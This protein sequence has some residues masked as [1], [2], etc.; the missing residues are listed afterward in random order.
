MT[1]NKTCIIKIF[2]FF[3]T[4]S[5]AALLCTS[6]WSAQR[7]PDQAAPGHVI[8]EIKKAEVRA[9]P[10]PE[11][12]IS[13]IAFK[14]E[15]FKVLRELPD[16][17]LIELSA[18][19]EGYL[20]KKYARVKKLDKS[21][22]GK[23]L[24]PKP[25][26]TAIEQEKD[27][28][29]ITSSGSYIR[30]TPKTN[31]PVIAQ[32]KINNAFKLSRKVS[33]SWYEIVLPNNKI[34]Y[35]PV[36]AAK[37]ITPAQ[38]AKHKAQRKAAI[39]PKTA[40]Q[41]QPAAAQYAVAMKNDIILRQEPNI[42]AKIMVTA[43]PGDHYRILSQE[44]DWCTVLLPDKRHAFVLAKVVKIVKETELTAAINEATRS[45]KQFKVNTVAVTAKSA[46]LYTKANDT[47][48]VITTAV[49]GTVFKLVWV[50]KD[51]YEV[52]T[53]SG[54][55]FI[56][57]KL[58]QPM[59]NE[60]PDVEPQ[61][62]PQPAPPALPVLAV[63]TKVLAEPEKDAW[64]KDKYVLVTANMVNLREAP[65]KNS[66][67]LDRANKD[68]TY[69]LLA[70]QNNWY[71]IFLPPEQNGFIASSLAEII[72]EAD[73]LAGPNKL[74]QLKQER[75]AA[76]RKLRL[77]KKAAEEKARKEEELKLKQENERKIKEDA[78]KR[79]AAIKAQEAEWLKDK[80][81]LINVRKAVLQNVPNIKG[82]ILA[83][84]NIGD[85]FKLVSRRADWY[86]INFSSGTAFINHN[87]GTILSET[88]LAEQKQKAAEEKARKEKELK[89]RQE[90]ERRIKEAA[91]Q[92]AREAA[93]LK[94][95][96]EAERKS[97]LEKQ[98]NEAKAREEEW[99]A[100]KYV[101]INKNNINL[102]KSP[103]KTA[104][105]INKTRN[106]ESFKLV[107]RAKDWYEISLS[108]G[109]AFIASSLA[110]VITAN[111]LEA[112]RAAERKAAAEKERL[113]A[114]AKAK[115]EAEQ[116]AKEEAAKKAREEAVQK[117]REAE[118]LKTRQ[119]AEAKAIDEAFCKD[120]YVAVKSTNAN[121]RAEP[122]L[123]A[124]I[125]ANAKRADIFKLLSR[126]QDWYEIFLP[127]DQNAFIHRGLVDILTE[128]DVES[129]IRKERA[130]LLRKQRAAEE[131]A[132][133][134]E[135]ERRAAEAEKTRLEAARIAKLEREKLLRAEA[136]LRGKE[137]AA[138]KAKEEEE[139]KAREIAWLKDKYIL[140][141]KQ[142]S[143][144][145][146]PN[147][148]ALVSGT[149]LPDTSFKIVTR[150]AEW[151]GVDT[152][153]GT[154]FVPIKQVKLMT[155]Q[156]LNDYR[157]QQ[158]LRRQ[159]KLKEEAEKK[160][161]LE[162]KQQAKLEAERKA[163]EELELKASLAAEEKA[164]KEAA[165]KAKIES[166]VQ[167][168]YI[169]IQAEN[170]NLRSAPSTSS[171]II[172][173]SK[174]GDYY[175]LT[176]IE[177]NEG[178]NSWYQV[179]VPSGKQSIKAYVHSS[180]AKPITKEE[181]DALLLARIPV[182]PIPA[183]EQYVL[184]TIDNTNLRKSASKNAAI[185][186]KA[187]LGTTYKLNSR[188]R[189][190]YEISTS[191]GTVFVHAG[192]TKIITA[193]EKTAAE[194]AER[195]AS[196][197]RAAKELK[198]RQEA[199]AKAKAAAELQAR[200]Q[201]KDDAKTK[202]FIADKYALAMV[203]NTNVRTAPDE[204]APPLTKVAGG[205]SFKV[206]WIIKDRLNV[207]WYQVSLSS[208]TQ[209]VEGYIISTL[210]KLL[211]K[212]QLNDYRLAQQ[213]ATEEKARKLRAAEELKLREEAE[214][215][216]RQEADRAAAELKVREEAERKSKLEKQEAEEKARMEDYVQD[217]YILTT[218]DNTNC[219]LAPDKNSAIIAKAKIDVSLKVTWITPDKQNVPWYQVAI[220]SGT[221]T[222]PAYVSSTVTKLMTIQ[223]L[224]E[225]RSAQQ[226]AAAEKARLET[227]AKERQ[228]TE[229]IAREE[230]ARKA[231]EE[232]ERLARAAAEL[233]AHEEA[234]RKSKLEKQAAEEKARMEDYVKDKYI[235]TTLANT[236]LREAPQQTATIIAKANNDVSLKV[237]WIAPNKQNVPWY[238]I[239]VPK[240]TATMTAYVLSTLVKLMTE[241]ELNEYRL[242]QQKENEEKARQ[243]R[244]AAELKAREE[245]ERKLKLEAERAAEEEWLKDKYVFVQSK[246][247]NIRKT[248]GKTAEIVQKA[249]PGQSFKIISRGKEWYE[250]ALNTGSAY[251][252]NT[253]VKVLSSTEL[254]TLRQQQEEAR[255]EKIKKEAEEKALKEAQLIAK[256]EAE[257]KAR[258]EKL[259]LEAEAKAK[260]TAELK[261][262]QE[263]EEKALIE[264]E[265]KAKE[266]AEAKAR[267]EAEAK[268]KMEAYVNDKYIV[269]SDNNAVI[270]TAPDIRASVLHVAEKNEAF[271]LN[272]IRD[273]WYEIKVPTGTAMAMG[274]VDVSSA[275][276]MTMNELS[277]WQK[278]QE[279]ERI[280]REAEERKDRQEAELKARAEEAAQKAQQELDRR[281]KQEVLRQA[282]EAERKSKLEK[283]EAEQKAL[284]EKERL[285]AE[286]KASEV[287][288]KQEADA[289]AKAAAELKAKIEA[290]Q[291]A[292]EAELKAKAEEEREDLAEYSY[293]VINAP[294]AEIKPVPDT[295][296]QA[297]LIGLKG[298]VFKYNGQQKGWYHVLTFSGETRFVRKTLCRGSNIAPQLPSGESKR[299]DIY[300]SL[301][302]AKDRAMTDTNI[303]Y[304]SIKSQSELQEKIFYQQT[305]EEKLILE[306][307]HQNKIQP[308]T[309]LTLLSEA[310]A[311]NW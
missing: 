137:A 31:G 163:K 262:R 22:S 49:Q 229:R 227:E 99:L 146:A 240:G 107:S 29:L 39:P 66:R 150:T 20:S 160:A 299:R 62:A 216:A 210:A 61:L 225:Y 296:A 282:Q 162:A 97:K 173:R 104:T 247:T 235:L 80:Y 243:L 267:I 168:K 259:K 194:E 251:I 219:R 233:K 218:L 11:A 221:A 142:T 85:S 43:K 69:K 27:Y 182:P 286:R 279:Q 122:K 18:N 156:E 24:V 269:I 54:T 88:G 300:D 100:D 70:R 284:A 238:Q 202:A 3:L 148:N 13:E 113:E 77:E 134:E 179:D 25:A 231:K 239:A 42:T 64:I 118:E 89:A 17:Y 145:P 86:E 309:Y 268:A 311:K 126:N 58:A 188:T 197:L 281:A 170:A 35:V 129:G 287:K 91:D 178:K 248:A 294:Y 102:R 33:G 121:L 78:A 96:E 215:R 288:M 124:N 209:T 106:G 175:K 136:D 258:E 196:E 250:I 117:K 154:V 234:E 130:A 307:C 15:I 68:N 237:T 289:K 161:R 53:S 224:N 140:V 60:K 255:L 10:D 21:K 74:A 177:N 40:P 30:K 246:D 125:L 245:A 301:I 208:G 67:I 144:Y 139:R 59:K 105:I 203:D 94:V 123:T 108:S 264:A 217:K 222:I 63:E 190:W 72:T 249:Q 19:K 223:E 133:Q 164:K 95:R 55:A 308:A 52:L 16:W 192:V 166:Q 242:A 153:S 256:L 1:K 275:K 183:P 180:L 261:A 276:S 273:N 5:V 165:A 189:D 271:K 109:T 57:D 290:E 285:S 110:D 230:T 9:A 90:N 272:W 103:N 12:K 147:K 92:R 34:S 128:A 295:N 260:A 131:L 44:S 50:F 302:D 252:H 159:E 56:S 213:K 236:N 81:V 157:L 195:K 193:A 205:E 198:A 201:A 101:I 206:T 278:V 143:V 228:E 4:L 257:Q 41:P 119:E 303:K 305:V 232:K 135:A 48:K 120:K 65:D 45:A 176:W 87:L 270:R 184:I 186:E 115:R 172:T 226:K 138:L 167:D 191:S 207:P 185:L 152:S 51:W 241:Q 204:N 93:E 112:K 212:K 141:N 111:D 199:E 116:L 181:L 98:E 149:A 220:P 46:K 37:I 274:F 310:I 132:K 28:V 304:P 211:T 151:Y 83:T 280:L 293:V 38:L 32:A 36:S 2:Y 253:V 298:D 292:K 187:K 291:I 174:A 171:P 75:Q 6:L 84:V 155:G 277:A 244:A 71:E 266:A 283:Q 114:E 8:V 214:S 158:E 26:P 79:E 263:A 14:G 200:Q 306:I 82:K 254:T 76:E 23:I 297:L 7:K 127:P 73:V 47:S 169:L 265:R